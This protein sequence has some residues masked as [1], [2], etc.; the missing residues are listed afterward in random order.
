MRTLRLIFI[1]TIALLLAAFL[2]LKLDAD[3]FF[4][5]HGIGGITLTYVAFSL[6]LACFV[7]FV[8]EA[9][10]LSRKSAVSTGQPAGIVLVVSSLVTYFALI[11]I[12]NVHTWTFFL[13]LIPFTMLVCG[14]ILYGAAS[15]RM[16]RVV[17]SKH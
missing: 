9:S 4:S 7:L 2:I 12:V 5:R 11:H 8:V 15:S 6:L 3:G 13:L 16:R 17:S 10:I 1:G 14:A